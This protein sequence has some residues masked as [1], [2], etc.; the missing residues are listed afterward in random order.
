MPAYSRCLL[1]KIEKQKP[2]AFNNEEKFENAL[3]EMLSKKGWEKEVLRHP[4]EK[5]LLKN[6]ANILFDNNNTIDRLNGQRLTEGEMQQLMDQISTLRTPQMLNGFINGR[7]VSVKRDNPADTL[8][9][10]K[11]IEDRKSVV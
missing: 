9:L 3:I 11:E 6:W 10:G 1:D 4:T 8:H 2:M 5:D 7:T